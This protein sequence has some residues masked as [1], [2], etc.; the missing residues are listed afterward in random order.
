MLK[1]AKQETENNLSSQEAVPQR[2][3]E[4]ELAKVVNLGNLE[5]IYLFSEDGLLIAGI[6]GRSD[7]NQDNASELVYSVHDGLE[8]LDN[9]TGFNGAIE[10][11]LLGRSRRRVSIRSFKTFGQ[12]VKLVLVIPKSKTY[13]FLTN[14]II[15]II[16]E[17]S[18]ASLN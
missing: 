1:I 13:R 16:R 9:A 3:I 11:L 5:C 12:N 6:Q 14:R 17:I 4:I 8:Y 15:R 2:Q 7:F 18:K 10:I